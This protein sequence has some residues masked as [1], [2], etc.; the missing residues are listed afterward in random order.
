MFRSVCA[1]LLDEI[2][3]LELLLTVPADH[4]AEEERAA[5]CDD[6]VGVARAPASTPAGSGV[7]R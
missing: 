7:V 4:A 1:E 5:P 3:G 2:V 6:A